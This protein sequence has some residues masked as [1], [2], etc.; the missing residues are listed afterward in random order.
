[1]D[2]KSLWSQVEK[3]NP[4]HTK[5]VNLGRRFTA[6]DAHYQIMRATEV[7]GPCGQG[8]GIRNSQYQVLAL[9]AQNPHYS[10]LQFTAQLWY[11]WDG[12]EGSF[13]IS[14]D[15][16]LFDDTRNGWKRA[17]DTHKK[18][19]TDA[20]TKGLSW[21][22]FNADVFMGKFGDSKYVQR[23]KNE[24]DQAQAVAAPAQA[25]QTEQRQKS[26]C[27]SC[28]A[29]I[30]WGKTAAGKANPYDWG[31]EASHFTT[32]PNASQHSKKAVSLPFTDLKEAKQ[33][34]W[35][36]AKRQKMNQSE[37]AVFCESQLS[38]KPEALTIEQAQQ[39]ID[40]LAVAA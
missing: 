27:K 1:M 11:I 21:L 17:E 25:E 13:D 8:W 36:A 28:E 26:K 5:E 38:V 7:F 39:L 4:A 10:L 40:K 29:D 35:N 24:Y 2:N 20:I 3:T 16:E 32:C 15:I 14:A 19:K 9:D 23:L 31:T 6:I 34:L 37:L 18:V 33:A 12:K 30:Y 22:G